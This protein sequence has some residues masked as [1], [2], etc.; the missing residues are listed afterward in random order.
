MMDVG[1]IGSGQIGVALAE[2]F[3]GAGHGVF[4]SN[5]RG[6][7]SLREL[8]S[9]LGPRLVPG[10]TAEV[11]DQ[12]IVILAVPWERVSEAVSGLDWSGKI[13]VDTSNAVVVDNKTGDPSEP[14]AFEIVDLGGRTSSQMVADMVPGARLVKA[15]NTLWADSL[16]SEPA[17]GGGQR[18]I[19][20]SG[21]DEEANRQVANL[22]GTVGWAPITLGTLDGGGLLQ[23]FPAGPLTTLDL[24]LY[25]RP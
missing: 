22:I 4:I 12:K 1:I 18:V 25:P 20:L 7:G 15:F 19:F 14:P 21:D 24:T 11:A 10:T 23:Q 17:K 6:P 9:R 8:A 2:Q 3:V 13:V 5:S 16:G